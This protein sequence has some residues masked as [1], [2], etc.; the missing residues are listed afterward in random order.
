[1]KPKYYKERY[2]LKPRSYRDVPGWINDAEY[3]F[4]KMV[5]K[6]QDGFH[7]VEIGVLLAQSTTHMAQLI[8]DSGK[9]IKFDSID[10]FWPIEHALRHH[11]LTGHPDSFAKYWNDIRE[12][13]DMT[14]V[15]TI[16]HPLRWLNLTDYVNFITCDEK[17]AHKIYGDNSL[18]FVWID[19]DHGEDIVYND[20]VNFW[21]KLKVGGTI[22]GDDIEYDEVSNDVKKFS[23]EYGVDV[24]YDTVVGEPTHNSI[25]I[26]KE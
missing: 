24:V 12:K 6:A 11:S 10:L 21:P 25:L 2:T 8:K 17:F 19:G 20:L 9:D 7:F 23:K 15:D 4:P 5:S 26:T 16:S 22:G 14:F 18:D 3:V 1:M 13:W